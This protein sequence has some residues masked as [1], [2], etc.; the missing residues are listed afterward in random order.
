MNERYLETDP[1]H[2]EKLVKYYIYI[3]EE[4]SI[5]GTWSNSFGQSLYH[6]LEFS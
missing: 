1:A 4:K 3:L 6:R 2:Q 5:F